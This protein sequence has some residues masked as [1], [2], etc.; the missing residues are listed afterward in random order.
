MAA[1]SFTTKAAKSLLC[2]YSSWTEVSEL[3]VIPHDEKTQITAAK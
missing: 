3:D 2:F 1:V